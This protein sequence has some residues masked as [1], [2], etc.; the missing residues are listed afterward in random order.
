MDLFD[1]DKKAKF[2]GDAPLAVRMRPGTLKE[3]VGQ[4]HILGKEGIL[5]KAIDNDKITSLMLYGPPGTGK[6]TLAYIIAN[7]KNLILIELMQLHPVFQKYARLLNP[8]ERGRI[9]TI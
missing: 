9:Q 3:F 6:T 2:N 8:Q 1:F 5:R 4:E 7:V